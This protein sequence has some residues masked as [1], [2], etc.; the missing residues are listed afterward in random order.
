M[1]KIILFVLLLVCVS[2]FSLPAKAG[3]KNDNGNNGNHYGQYKDHDNQAN[4]VPIDGGI[5]LL[6]AAGIGYGVKRISDKKKNKSLHLE[7]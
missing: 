3:D 2:F 5:A 1:N 6:F 4:Q 7:A